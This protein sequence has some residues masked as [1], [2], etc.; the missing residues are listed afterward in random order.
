MP[1]VV[2]NRA[3]SERGS[4][5]GS[6]TKLSFRVA[7]ASKGAKEAVEKA[8]GSVEVIEVVAAADKHKAKHRVAQKARA[9]DKEAKKAAAKG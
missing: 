6:G 3:L 9:A 2:P 4:I 1:R 7:G 8:G 5:P